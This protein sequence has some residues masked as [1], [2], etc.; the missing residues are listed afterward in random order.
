MAQRSSR[1]KKYTQ[2]PPKLV[3]LKERKIEPE[4][5]YPE[6]GT[7][8]TGDCL[9]VMRLWPNH[10]FDH[11]ITDPPFGISKK[12][13]LGWAFSSHI[14]MQEAWD[15]FSK[16]SYLSFTRAWISEVSRLVKPNGNIL[17]FGTYH[18]IYQVGFVLQE[19]G[20]RVINSIIW[21]KPNAQPNIT[22]RTLT[23]S[24]EQIVWAVNNTVETA[25]GWTFNYWVAKEI[26][27]G[28]QLRNM[29]Q[30]PYTPLREKRY[31]K[32]PTQKPEVLL[33]RL[34]KIA[35]K[36]NDLIL[37]CFS[38]AGTTGVVCQRLNRRWIMIEKD[39]TYNE[40][41]RKRLSEIQKA[42]L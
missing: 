15:R 8:Y 32:H 14:T 24:T 21:F 26:G 31:G 27:N 3:V 18:N 20:L 2:Q 7:I 35:T 34:I 22:T 1:K 5:K 40:L 38:G 6:P 29:W 13:G 19:L 36:E 30:I 10:I 9:E 17:I 11:C 25:K 12:Q 16:D 33:E 28:K 41:A 39:H 4:L 23:E 37:D 42:L